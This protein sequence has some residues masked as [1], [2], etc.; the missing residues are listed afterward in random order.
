MPL[1]KRHPKK[2]RAQT[3]PPPNND[4]NKTEDESAKNG[5][6]AAQNTSHAFPGYL[7]ILRT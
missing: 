6:E 1:K 3:Y 4:V 2:K 7:T 5:N